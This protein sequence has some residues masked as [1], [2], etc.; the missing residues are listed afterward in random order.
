MGDDYDNPFDKGVLPGEDVELGQVIG[1][2]RSFIY[3]YDFGDGWRHRITIEKRLPSDPL[4]KP[5]A[6]LDDDGDR[7]G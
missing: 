3:E 4:R 5:A 2:R 1:R 7:P 6:L